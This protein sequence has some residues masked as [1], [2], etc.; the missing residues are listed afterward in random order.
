VDVT[1]GADRMGHTP[2][3]ML[4]KYATGREDKAIA[5]ATALEDRLIAQGLPMAELFT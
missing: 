1:V 2:Q 5:A 3:M 4:T